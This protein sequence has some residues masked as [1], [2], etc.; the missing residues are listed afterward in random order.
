MKKKFINIIYI[1]LIALT[2]MFQVGCN[3]FLD[4]R[5]EGE[6][7]GS[8]LLNKPEGFESALYGAYASLR[9][10]NLYGMTLS[11]QMTEVLAQYFECY[12]NE[13]VN[14]LNDY[15]YKSS[16]VESSI[17]NVWADMY[18]NIANVNNIIISLE[19]FSE[20]DFRHYNLYKGEALGL[21]AFMHFEILR[22][23]TKNIQLDNSAE[24][25]PYSKKFALEPSDFVSASKAYELVIEDLV[26]AEKL[27]AQDADLFT[28]PKNNPDDAFIRDRETHFNLYA[29]QAT[30]ARVYFTMG[31]YPNAAIQAKKV[32][33][34]NKFELLTKSDLAE[35]IMK[36]IIYPKEAIFGIYSTTYY[37][38]V[39][40]R[41]YFETSF[42]SYNPRK[43]IKSIYEK[44][45]RGHDYRWEGFFKTPTTSTGSLRFI[46]LVDQYMI[47]D[48]EWQRPA[49]YIP[50]I[51]MIRLPEMYY[52]L[53]ESLLSSSPQEAA[54]Y[55]DTVLESRGLTGLQNR[56][57]ANEK[58]LTKERITDERYKE[59]IGEG[60]T[61]LNMKRLNSNIIATDNSVIS[62]SDAIYV[63]PIP[64]DEL[65]YNPKK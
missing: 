20:K 25:I 46:K 54:N 32:V 53:A 41:F 40:E 33:N 16:I 13:F 10:N 8:Q 24:G 52:I 38:T 50:G 56:D 23:F 51:N 35:G 45:Q 36:G 4:I 22:Y 59:F 39:R 30:L 42:S 44:E 21:R 18:T 29:V 1:N 12:G 15:N 11:H 2:L 55:F 47:D 31:D 27:L 63:W 61:F 26:E 19:S 17:D 48:R 6:L 43:D 28:Y 9:T 49:A 62:A 65:E 14:Q 7:P 37:N 5:P 64:F 60:Q 34:S 57:E 58:Q 3:S